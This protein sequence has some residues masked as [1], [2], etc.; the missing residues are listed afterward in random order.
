LSFKF[1][2]HTA[3][4]IIH[5]TGKNLQE[6]F[7]QAALGF[8]TVVTEPSTVKENLSKEVKL[9][10]ENIESLLYDWIDQ[11]IFW[12]DTEYFIGHRIQVLELKKLEDGKFFLSAKVFGEEFDPNR[13]PQKTE[14]KAMT[15]SFMKVGENFVEFTLDL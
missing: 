13:H 2:D 4:V 9:I 12:F 15:Y 10:S 6:A 7:E 5:A 14:V 11:L 1:L 8:F 3:D